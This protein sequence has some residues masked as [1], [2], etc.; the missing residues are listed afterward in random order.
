MNIVQILM[1]IMLAIQITSVITVSIINQIL[2]KMVKRIST[3]YLYDD[4]FYTN[5]PIYNQYK[6]KCDRLGK[7]RNIIRDKLITIN[8]CII[9]ILAIVQLII[10]AI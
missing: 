3:V 2:K 10:C 4:P 6:V 7:A 1:L 5:K 8:H 9:L